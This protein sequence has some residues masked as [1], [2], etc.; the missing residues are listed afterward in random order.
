MYMFS[1]GKLQHKNTAETHTENIKNLENAHRHG[2]RLSFW[3]AHVEA[4]NVLVVLSS[5]IKTMAVIIIRILLSTIKINSTTAFGFPELACF[6]SQD[7]LSLL[8]L[9]D[10]SEGASRAEGE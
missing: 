8:T 6:G 4:L 9:A 5:T 7:A 1:Q 2:V 3:N 10:G